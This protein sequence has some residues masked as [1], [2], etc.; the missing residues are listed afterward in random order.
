MS[1]L[2]TYKD[3]VLKLYESGILASLKKITDN[4]F[5]GTIKIELNVNT[6]G[7]GNA[8]IDTRE[9]IKK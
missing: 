4:S 5:T 9:R 1:D 7:I 6:G 2:S 3:L 8:Y